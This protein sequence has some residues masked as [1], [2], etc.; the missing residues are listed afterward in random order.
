MKVRIDED[1][2]FYANDRTYT[3]RYR[4]YNTDGSGTQEIV[5]FAT[6]S[7]Q[8]ISVAN[9][10]EGDTIPDITQWTDVTFVLNARAGVGIYRIGG[11]EGTFTFDPNGELL[12]IQFAAS[13]TATGLYIDDLSVV[14][15]APETIVKTYTASVTWDDAHDYAGI[16]P[17]SLALTLGGQTVTVNEDCQWQA[18]FTLPAFN[19]D[20]SEISYTLSASADGYTASVSEDGLSA[21]LSHTPVLYATN[22]DGASTTAYF[23]NDFEGYYG[24]DGSVLANPVNHFY[25]GA[26]HKTAGQLMYMAGNG[27]NGY[28]SIDMT[29]A[30]SA[31][32]QA[33]FVGYE[34]GD[35]TVSFKLSTTGDYAPVGTYFQ[36]RYGPSSTEKLFKISNLDGY[37]YK[38]SYLNDYSESFTNN[39]QRIESGAWVTVHVVFHMSSDGASDT[40]DLYI[41]ETLA[42]SGYELPARDS[43]YNT[44]QVRLFIPGENDGKNLLVDDF[45]VYP[46]TAI[47]SVDEVK[48]PGYYFYETG[49]EGEDVIGVDKWDK[50]NV[51]VDPDVLKEAVN[52]LNITWPDT[53]AK[54]TEAMNSAIAL[55][56]MVL[57]EHMTPGATSSDGVVVADEAAARIKLLVSGGREPWA[58]IGCHWG[59]GVVA[60][61]MA[62]AKNTP[63]IWSKL[64]ADDISRVD[65]L[66]EC[67]AIAANWGYNSQNSYTTGFDLAGD[68][69]RNGANFINAYL[70]C[71]MSA[72]MYFDDDGNHQ[73]NELDD[74]FTSFNYDSYIARLKEYGFTNILFVWTT[75]E[76]NGNQQSI[77]DYMTNGGD[78][79]LNAVAESEKSG[80][81]GTSGGTGV[82]VKVAFSYTSPNDSTVYNSRQLTEIFIDTIKYTYSWQVTSSHNSPDDFGKVFS[83]EYAYLLT[84]EVNPRQGQM[85]MMREYAQ[86]SR[87][88]STYCYLS[89]VNIAPLYANMKLLGYWDYSD[90]TLMR[91]MDNRIY[92]GTE[93]LFWKMDQGYYSV[94]TTGSGPEYWSTFATS[95]GG[96]FIKDIFWNFHFAK[97]ADITWEPIEVQSVLEEA[98][99]VD[100]NYAGPAVDAI[101]AQGNY[102]HGYNL[103]SN[104]VY[105]FDDQSASSNVKV[106]F[107]LVINN[108]LIPGSFKAYIMLDK[109]GSGRTYKD[110]PVVLYLHDGLIRASYKNGFWST[111]ARF[112]ENYRYHVDIEADCVN[113]VYNITIRQTW[114]EADGESDVV[115]YRQNFATNSY[116]A[117][118]T[119][120]DSIL[121]MSS[122]LQRCI[123]VE[124][125]TA[126]KVEVITEQ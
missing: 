42:K 76:E 16:R 65:L 118:T 20:G 48:S 122:Y 81:A 45:M 125:L 6:L 67:L 23:Y 53:R 3:F 113:Q 49:I 89:A 33:N 7:A 96:I 100:S 121:V 95:M 57:S 40:W 77:G 62:L 115:F 83:E 18:D 109:A 112:G 60:T 12:G 28:M 106:S 2:F 119:E 99:P 37:V 29:N 108:N 80:T 27:T 43:S 84:D 105:L 110:A 26:T 1:A 102:A 91:Q 86:N 97:N 24:Q 61:T 10:I 54:T 47:L 15:K 50:E 94:S 4:R 75:Q 88:R 31:Y 73:G 51:T 64:S 90:E 117:E 107:D 21:T 25:S 38:G 56:Y 34:G 55:Y 69:S 13:A 111:F 68:F 58:S 17:D 85:G 103:E 126:E 11:A 101:Y 59:H 124:N 30:Q 35:F 82:G 123:W 22:K 39:K 32:Y 98:A 36:Y 93:D 87:S 120:I 79:I 8:S 41:N 19:A 70:T 116:A 78:V 66:M 114:P 14:D 104:Y 71:Y 5:R 52:N 63:T 44:S 92:V 9:V 74:I 72:A 46:G